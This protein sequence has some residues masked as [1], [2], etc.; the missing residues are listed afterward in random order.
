LLAAAICH[1]AE[2]SGWFTALVA[3][4]RKNVW[5]LCSVLDQIAPSKARKNIG[6]VTTLVSTQ[7][8]GAYRRPVE[9]GGGTSNFYKQQQSELRKELQP[10]DCEA[11][12]ETCGGLDHI[13]SG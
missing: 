1:N 8:P 3:V 2:F 5:P 7:T 11:H 10:R 6:I 12:G 4:G 9:D 13:D